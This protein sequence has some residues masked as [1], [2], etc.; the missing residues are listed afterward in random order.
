MAEWRGAAWTSINTGSAVSGRGNPEKDG[1]ASRHGWQEC[2]QGCE[3]A[4]GVAYL[5]R[6]FVAAG[7]ASYWRSSLLT[8]VSMRPGVYRTGVVPYSR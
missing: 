6:L 5:I 8:R 3:G 4:K 7:V 2:S 1:V